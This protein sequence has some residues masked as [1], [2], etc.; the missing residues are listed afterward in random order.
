[1]PLEKDKDYFVASQCCCCCP[2]LL[3]ASNKT[4]FHNHAQSLEVKILVAHWTIKLRIQVAGCIKS[5][6]SLVFVLTRNYTM[7]NEAVFHSLC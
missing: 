3:K 6:Q 5:L 2:H 4:Q 7:A 1:M